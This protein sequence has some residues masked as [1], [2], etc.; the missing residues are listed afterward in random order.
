MRK[1]L[2]IAAATPCQLDAIERAL[3]DLALHLDSHAQTA[4]AL[5]A[6]LA[7]IRRH[8]PNKGGESASR[9]EE[10]A[11]EWSLS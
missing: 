3:V 4:Q 5:A 1:G 10:V 11:R 2:S 9:G 7:D 8:H 6:Q